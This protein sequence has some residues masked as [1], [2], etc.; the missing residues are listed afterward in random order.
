MTI[1][2]SLFHVVVLRGAAALLGY[3]FQVFQKSG[4]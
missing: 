3:G 2:L 4:K 1:R